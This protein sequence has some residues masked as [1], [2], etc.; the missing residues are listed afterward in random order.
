MV[1]IYPSPSSFQQCNDLLSS[2]LDLSHEHKRTLSI[3]ETERLEKR[4]C[5]LYPLHISRVSSDRLFKGIGRS[6]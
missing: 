1:L 5:L 4:V 3:W 6:Y 2:I